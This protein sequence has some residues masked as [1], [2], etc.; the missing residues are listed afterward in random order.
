MTVIFRVSKPTY[1]VGF[2]ARY[3]AFSNTDLNYLFL[4]LN[5]ELPVS[6]KDADVKAKRD[7]VNKTF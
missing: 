2:S 7:E 5:S 3:V 1:V 4:L 6:A